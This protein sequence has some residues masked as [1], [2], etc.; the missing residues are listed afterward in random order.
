[1]ATGPHIS[2]QLQ[3][4]LRGDLGAPER[5]AAEAHL[6]VCPACREERDLLA[7]AREIVPELAPFEPRLGF[8][9][10]VASAAGDAQPSGVQRWLRFSFAGMAAAAAAAVLMVIFV[11]PGPTHSREVMLAQR[12]DLFEDMPVMQNQQALED[13]EVV[14]VL[15]TLEARP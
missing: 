14:E 12:L 15:H 3:A 8:A 5:A 10:K 11:H 1:M 4:L 6:A 2:S 9:A 7:S 13:L